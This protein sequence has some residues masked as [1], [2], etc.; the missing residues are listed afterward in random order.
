MH[1][2]C[3]VVC[4]LVIAL[5]AATGALLA[6]K[7]E[8]LDLV[9]RDAARVDVVEG[10]RRVSLDA[11]VKSA[12]ERGEGAI[13]ASLTVSSDP[14]AALVVST[15]RTGGFFA[16]P[17]T[18][19]LRE[20][21]A[22]AWES[23]FGF[24]LELHRWLALGGERRETGKAVT[25]A[26]ALVLFLLCV[27]G[28][29]LWWPRAWNA[30]ALRPILLPKRGARGRARDWNRHHVFGIW[31]LPVLL[32]ISGTGVTLSY[33][34]ASNLLFVAVGEAP[35]APRQGP[36][37]DAREGVRI[38]PPRPGA[39]PLPLDTLLERACAEA[40]DWKSVSFRLASPRRPG[41][42]PGR[43]RADAPEAVSPEGAAAPVRAPAVEQGE[44]PRLG[45][46]APGPVS[47]TV[48]RAGVPPLFASVALSFNPYTGE[49]LGRETFADK[50]PGTRLRLAARFLH[51]GEGLGL[52]GKT[53]AFLGA[54]AALML[55]WTG[56]ALF[57][58]RFRPRPDGGV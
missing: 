26:C 24:I 23:A 32:L 45:L 55:V 3:G 8:V 35:P 34:W 27:S 49:L 2:A 36:P 20:Q 4:G 28:L 21:G 44:E 54:L 42:R 29:F 40:P 25:G 50:S 30:R 33:R 39:R 12:R 9:R 14:G 19:E 53:L 10:A 6:F 1:L 18:G 5:L 7:A 37:A 31:A 17:Y 51:T 38:E 11:V 15:G 48:V 41:A 47:V 46:R 52:P 16:N 58:R 22:P 56:F 13:P 57:W 43:P